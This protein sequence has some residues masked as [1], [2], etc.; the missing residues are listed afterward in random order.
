[1]ATSS[2][3]DTC[4]STPFN[5]C[6]DWLPRGVE[7]GDA[8]ELNHAREDTGGPIPTLDH[9]D[10]LPGSTTVFGTLLGFEV[11]N[12]RFT[13]QINAMIRPQTSFEQL[14]LA[15]ALVALLLGLSVAAFA[16]TPPSSREALVKSHIDH[17]VVYEQGAQVE[18]LAE[19]TLNQGT[20]MIVFHDLS[21]AIDPSKVRLSGR[22]D[23]TVL[24]ISH[25][26][27]TDTLGGAD[28]N[29]ERMR[30]STLRNALNKDIQH[31]Q[32][33]RVL[34]TAKSS[35]CCK[36]KIL[37]SRTPASICNG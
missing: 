17:V 24:G 3:E 19:V 4:M 12:R 1:M 23:F 36:T 26:Y 9:L 33:R 29:E 31:A 5:T 25:R 16:T 8:L 15:A 22:G 2:P 14:L 28:S 13:F 20:N 18:R 30:L 35:S 10:L 7:F 32:T 27:H 37:K 21:T 6:S 34:L 11:R